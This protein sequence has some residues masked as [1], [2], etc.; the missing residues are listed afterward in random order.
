MRIFVSYANHDKRQAG[1]L[2][3]YLEEIYGF[4]VFLAHDDIAPTIEWEEAILG[5]LR[6]CDVMI[7]FLTENFDNSVWTDQ[8]T[9]FALARGAKI[10]PLNAGVN[11]HGFIAR[12]QALNFHDVESAC[13]AI[14]RIIAN[15]PTLRESILDQLIEVLGN[16]PTYRSAPKI[17]ELI[18]EFEGGLTGRQLNQII[19]V[20]GSNNQIYR[21]FKAKRMLSELISRHREQLNQDDVR[22]FL[23]RAS[24]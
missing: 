6:A 14:V 3:R 7:L 10:I 16:S 20:S 9:G 17:L 18:L 15:T 12:L 8:E 5:E 2:K 13:I 22:I 11:P 4:E 21:S 1:N 23:S 19:G 24:L